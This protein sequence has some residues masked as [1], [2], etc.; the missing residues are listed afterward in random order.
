MATGLR[1]DF[2][3]KY[4]FLLSLPAVLGAN[5]LSLVKAI[6]VGIDASLLPAYLIGMI[7]VQIKCWDTIKQMN[8]QW[9]LPE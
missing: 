1:R 2:A 8:I 4:S 3:V 5:I 9:M 6:K 7:S